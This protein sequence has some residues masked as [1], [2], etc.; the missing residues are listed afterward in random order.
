MIDLLVTDSKDK[1]FNCRSDLDIIPKRGNKRD[2]ESSDLDIQMEGL[3]IFGNP[4][5]LKVL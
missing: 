3:K 1:N 2:R 5:K 4:R